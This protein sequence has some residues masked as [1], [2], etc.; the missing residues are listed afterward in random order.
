MVTLVFA[1]YSMNRQRKD[2]YYPLSR[3]TMFYAIKALENLKHNVKK[4]VIVRAMDEGVFDPNYYDFSG[5]NL[6]NL[7]IE[8]FDVEN[9]HISCGQWTKYLDSINDDNYD[10]LYVLLEDDYTYETDNFDLLIKNEYQRLFPDNIGLLTDVAIKRQVQPLHWTGTIVLSADSIKQ[11][12]QRGSFFTQLDNVIKPRGFVSGGDIQLMISEL[13]TKNNL[14]YRSFQD[15]YDFFFWFTDKKTVLYFKKDPSVNQ[16]LKTFQSNPTFKK[17]VN[18]DNHI[19][20]YNKTKYHVLNIPIQLT[21]E[22]LKDV[23]QS[24]KKNYIN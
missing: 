18:H 3:K 8:F 4:I 1:S 22:Y 14:A 24:F 20:K 2:L 7:P 6:A 13:F 21:T 23:P 5:I 10:D 19:V 15:T 9:Q 17:L 12:K 11:I 16:V